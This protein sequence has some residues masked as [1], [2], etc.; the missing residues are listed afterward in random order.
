MSYGLLLAAHCVEPAAKEEMV[1][2]IFAKHGLRLDIEVSVGHVGSDRSYPYIKVSSLV[3][4]LDRHGKLFK[5]LGMGREFDTLEKCEAPL[6]D[7]WEKYQV[8]NG[9]HEVYQLAAS[10]HLKLQNCLPCLIHGDEGTTYKKDG[11]LVLSIHSI[12]GLGTR[13]SRAGP[14]TDEMETNLG[15]N[16]LGHAFQTRFL[17]GALLK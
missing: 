2:R 10:G 14:V 15:T 4:A 5:L 13:S 11:C 12:L 16:F 9:N 3:E 7:F 6:L 17:L 8:M 1:S